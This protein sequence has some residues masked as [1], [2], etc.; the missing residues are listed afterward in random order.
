[1][2]DPV[3]VQ[4]DFYFLN[5]FD[6]SVKLVTCKQLADTPNPDNWQIPNE[7]YGTVGY[8]IFNSISDMKEAADTLFG[9]KQTAFQTA[10]INYETIQRS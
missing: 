5:Q 1:M 3:Y 2:A 4:K 9:Y 7:G 10:K 8:V 6:L